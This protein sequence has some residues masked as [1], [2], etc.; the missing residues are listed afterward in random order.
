MRPVARSG[1]GPSTSDSAGLILA[2]S[3]DPQPTRAWDTGAIG[4]ERLGARLNELA[5]DELRVLHDRKIPGSSANIDHLA[6]TPE[7]RLRD[8]R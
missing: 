8:R 1:S 2:V 5:G 7:R 6:V 3:D 4:D